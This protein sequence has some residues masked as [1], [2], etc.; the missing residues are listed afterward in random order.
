MRSPASA[1]PRSPHRQLAYWPTSVMLMP[2]N[3]GA[4]VFRPAWWLSRTGCI[5]TVLCM[6]KDLADAN[7]WEGMRRLRELRHADT[8]HSWQWALNPA[9][10]CYMPP[11]EYA[12]AVR[13]LLGLQFTQ[14]AVACAACDGGLLLPTCNHAL[15]CAPG[16]CTRGHNTVR[17]EVMVLASLADPHT[18]LEPCGVI[19]DDPGARPADLLTSAALAGCSAALDVGIASPDSAG[20][21]D[22][23]CEGLRR[24]KLSKYSTHLSDLAAQGVRYVPFHA[25]ANVRLHPDAHAVLRNLAACA[26]RRHGNISAVALLRRVRA[27]IS[28]RIWRRAVAMVRA[29]LPP[30]SGQQADALLGADPAGGA[31]VDVPGAALVLASGGL[32]ALAA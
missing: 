29:C 23:C 8:D 20:A 18:Q 15:R 10:G 19:P 16:E 2:I 22:D 3:K 26:A 21:G 32:A 30:L 14:D 4:W 27:R 5:L 9:H 6:T 7:D 1:H 24:S 13:I 31:D 25:S 11:D 28:V 17:D 12:D